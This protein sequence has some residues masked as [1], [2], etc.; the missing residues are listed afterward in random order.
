MRCFLERLFFDR[1]FRNNRKVRCYSVRRL[2]VTGLIRFGLADA[3]RSVLPCP[4]RYK[5]SAAAR[6]AREASA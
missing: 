2:R 6:G 3:L 4:R 1:A 5:D